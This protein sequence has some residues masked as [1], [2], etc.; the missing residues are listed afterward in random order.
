MWKGIKSALLAVSLLAYIFSSIS[1]IWPI[2]EGGICTLCFWLLECLS[3][4]ILRTEPQGKKLL[5]SAYKMEKETTEK[6]FSMWV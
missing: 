2:R 4:Y 1:V 6:M 3:P 5:G